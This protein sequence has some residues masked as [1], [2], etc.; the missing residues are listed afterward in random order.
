MPQLHFQIFGGIVAPLLG[1]TKRFVGTE[2]PGTVTDVYN[3]KLKQILP[4]YGIEIIVIKRLESKDGEVVS[5]SETRRIIE[6][7]EFNKL[8]KYLSDPI[9][10]YIKK[11]WNVK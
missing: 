11:K 6:A 3:E 7:G 10:K 8:N 5:A 9:I 4:S 2:I 1:I